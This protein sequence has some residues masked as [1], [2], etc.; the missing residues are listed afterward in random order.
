MCSII[1]LLQSPPVYP[2]PA[3]RAGASVSAWV[4]EGYDGKTDTQLMEKPDLIG[5]GP[6]C[7]ARF[8]F[9]GEGEK[10]LQFEEGDYIRLL[11]KIGDEWAQGEINGREGIFPLVYVE[12]IEDLPTLD[13]GQE[14][15]ISP[16][17]E[18]PHIHSSPPPAKAQVSKGYQSVTAMYDFS[19]S[20]PGDLPLNVRHF[21]IY[22]C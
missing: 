2:A 7:C 12:I 22:Y 21:I 11:E 15:Q 20:D 10:D 8:D 4:E 1:G 5:H 17:T 3:D 14:T 16:E 18:G 13:R 9:E 6:R 19:A